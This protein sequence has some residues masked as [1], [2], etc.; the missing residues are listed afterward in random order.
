VAHDLAPLL[1]ASPVFGN[2]LP[3]KI[4]PCLSRAWERQPGMVGL[5]A[6][7]PSRWV[8]CYGFV[9][10]GAEVRLDLGFNAAQTR[11]ADLTGAGQLRHASDDA[12]RDLGSGLARVGP[13]GEEPGI[14][15]LVS[16]RFGEVTVREGFAVA[17]MR[18]QATGPGG[19]LFPALDADITLTKMGN[20]ATILAV[21]GV[22]RPPF[23]V[24]GAGLDRMVMRRVAQATIR[25]FVDRIGAAITDRAA[26]AGAPDTSLLPDSPPCSGP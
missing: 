1:P 15:K 14:S 12:Y 23:G 4:I 25:T 19:T 16:V 24:L 9:F 17:A 22:Y 13:L 11:L 26:S 21:W 7:R 3:F 6:L 18:W 5:M 2:D 10:I 20:D 8:W